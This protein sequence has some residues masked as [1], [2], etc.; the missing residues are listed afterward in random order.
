[1]VAAV[2]RASAVGDHDDGEIGAERHDRADHRRLGLVVEGAGRFVEDQH[3][4]PFVE[5]AG[6]SDPLALAARQ[7]DAALADLGRIALRQPLDEIVDM[8]G[9]GAG[10]HALPVDGGSRHAEGDIGGDALVDEEDGLGN[11][12][13]RRLPARPRFGI[14]RFAV[15]PDRARVRLEQA[16]QQV[17]QRALPAPRRAGDADAAAALDDEADVAH[18]ETGF[19]ISEGDA[20]ERDLAL[21]GQGRAAFGRRR[22]DRQSK[23]RGNVVDRLEIARRLAP[24]LIGLLDQ[25]QQPLRAQSERAEHRNGMDEAGRPQ[26]HRQRDRGDHRHSRRFD[27]EAR[28][29]GDERIDRDGAAET[30]VEG[31]KASLEQGLGPVEDDVADASQPFLDHLGPLLRRRRQQAGIGAQP[32]SGQRGDGRIDE[33]DRN[34]RRD[35]RQRADREQQRA[36]QQGHD[37]A[38]DPL[39]QRLER[40]RGEVAHLVHR[41]EGIAAVALH[42]I[43]IR[44]AQHPAEQGGGDIVAHRHHESLI[45]P[46]EQ[47]PNDRRRHRSGDQ[48]QRG[49][50]DAVDAEG[51]EPSPRHPR[52]RRSPAASEEGE[53]G[54]NGG[55]RDQLRDGAGQHRPEGEEK[56]APAAAVEGAVEAEDRVHSRSMA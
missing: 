41:G 22:Q 42:I 46:E 38:D 30:P 19:A 7:A 55:D 25:G 31:A 14:E 54:K 27:D 33:A 28:P 50:E 17:E 32:R 5:G 20:V 24:A 26:A 39:H 44:L 35:R 21:E 1:M 8:G 2:E 48:Q 47:Q 3:L 18:G 53:E 11:M 6:D 45:L 37:R 16:H 29:L 40:A 15:H 23:G 4:R 36:D 9:A 10:A 49:R 13:E 12:G 51:C 43:R 34:R 52:H 56:L